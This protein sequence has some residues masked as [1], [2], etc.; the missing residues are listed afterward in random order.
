MLLEVVAEP[1]ADWDIGVLDAL[2]MG[3]I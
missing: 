3:A 2:K 1:C